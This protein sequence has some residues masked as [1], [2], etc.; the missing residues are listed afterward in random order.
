MASRRRKK[1]RRT[2][3]PRVPARVKKRTQKTRSPHHPELWGLAMTAVGLFLATVV[4]LGWNGGPV[5]SHLAD[6]LDDGLGA[7]ST[8]VP[9]VLTSVGVLLLVRS[10]LVD[11]RP[12]RTGLVVGSLG[13]MIALGKD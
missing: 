11:V 6:W 7:A 5:G 2:L 1:P 12:F 4:W 3:R 10:A 8:L 9:L 13:L